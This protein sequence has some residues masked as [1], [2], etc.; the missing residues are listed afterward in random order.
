M[1]SH[2]FVCLLLQFCGLELYHLTPSAVLHIAAFVTLCDTYMG[3]EPHFNLQNY[4]FR[5]R[6]RLRVQ[7]PCPRGPNLGLSCRCLPG[8]NVVLNSNVCHSRFLHF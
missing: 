7:S 5:I 4:F 1:L 2:K 6:L 3:I 8:M